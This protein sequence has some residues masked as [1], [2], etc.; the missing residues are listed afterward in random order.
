M[1]KFDVKDPRLTVNGAG[2]HLGLELL[3]VVATSP[4]PEEH[5]TIVRYMGVMGEGGRGGGRGRG[6]GGVREQHYLLRMWSTP[7]PNKHIQQ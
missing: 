6:V 3:K 1:V 7:P 5:G 4:I 2:L